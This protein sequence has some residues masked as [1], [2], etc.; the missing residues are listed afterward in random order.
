MESESESLRRNAEIGRYKT[1]EIEGENGRLKLQVNLLTED[2]ER[3]RQGE[4]R[5]YE[6]ERKLVDAG[7]S[8]EA[9][10]SKL[11]FTAKENQRFKQSVL[12][13]EET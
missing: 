11:D 1:S 3:Y 8:M 13:L 12:E 4:I 2:V 9:V 7:I 6:T 10:K 5:V